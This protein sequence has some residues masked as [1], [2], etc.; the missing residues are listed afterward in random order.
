MNATKKMLSSAMFGHQNDCARR[1]KMDRIVA[2][3]TSISTPYC[4]TRAEN[5]RV[6]QPLHYRKRCAHLDFLELEIAQLVDGERL[7]RGVEER[8]GVQPLEERMHFRAVDEQASEQQAIEKN[9]SSA[10]SASS[11]WEKE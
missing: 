4:G 9:T 7:E 3:G 5:A 10:P 2:A 11:K 6:S 8:D 1:P